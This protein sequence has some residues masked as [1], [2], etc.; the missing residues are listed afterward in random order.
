MNGGSEEIVFRVI[1]DP[2]DL[3]Q[4]LGLGPGVVAGA[5]PSGV[6]GGGVIPTQGQVLPGQEGGEGQ[7]VKQDPSFM[8]IFKPLAALTVMEKALGGILKH[9]SVANTYLG[10]MGK[11]F[12]AAMDMLLLPLTPLFNLMMTVM[13]KL[14]AWLV[15]SGILEKLHAIFTKVAEN[16]AGMLSWLS[17][18]WAALK[19]FD[20][21]KMAELSFKGLKA[22]VKEAISNPLESLAT[23]ATGYVGMKIAGRALAAIG[24]G[25]AGRVAGGA[26]AGAGGRGMLGG[27]AA[28]GGRGL[29]GLGGLAGGGAMAGAAVLG[30]GAAGAGLGYYGWTQAGKEGAAGWMGVG[31]MAAGGALL[32]GAVGSVVPG[33]GTLVGAGVGGAIGGG[34]G[35]GK[36]LGL[37]GGGGGEGGGAPNLSNVGNTMYVNINIDAGGQLD[38]QEVAERAVG[39]LEETMVRD[40]GYALQTR[41]F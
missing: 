27:A 24:L 9:S 13:S 15:T 10:A 31:G 35:L 26:A 30:A 1:L 2:S 11:M 7:K 38:E 14:L 36:Q 16:I 4:I 8:S 5:A 40:Q 6:G 25:G 32:G 21:G 12:G 19:D 39:E 23:V 33:V 18:I 22:V 37:F 29:M 3:K 34:I 28:M 41:S 17:D 20:V